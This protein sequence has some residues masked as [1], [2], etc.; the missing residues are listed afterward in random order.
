MEYEIVSLEVIE[1][2]L[3]AA[4]RLIRPLLAVYVQALSMPV[5]L[6][7]SDSELSMPAE[8]PPAGRDSTREA[9]ELEVAP[10]GDLTTPTKPTKPTTD[11]SN[12]LKYTAEPPK[13]AVSQVK[14]SRKRTMT[15]SKKSDKPQSLKVTP[16]GTVPLM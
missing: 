11:S 9:R 13:G 4:S 7:Q 14:A 12:T 6:A 8:K 15:L 10:D 16:D 1:V 5:L 3:N 2:L